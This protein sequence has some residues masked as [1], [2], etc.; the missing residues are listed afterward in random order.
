[1]EVKFKRQNVQMKD[2]AALTYPLWYMT[3]HREFV[4]TAEEIAK[5]Q[6]FVKAGGIFLA[7]ACCG[8]SSFD[9]AFRREIRRAFPDQPLQPIPFDHP[10][11][12]NQFNIGK[13]EY[14]PRTYED[15]GQLERPELEA[16]M[17][18][19]KPGVIYSRFDLGNGWEQFPHAY[20]YGLKDRSAL[21]IGANILVYAVTH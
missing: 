21:E 9:T 14:S 4:F 1:M 2:P 8:R 16:V 19:G 7:D 3:G 12:S 20:S 6:Q 18:D 17:L 10:I 13:V 11:Y 15:F 5:L